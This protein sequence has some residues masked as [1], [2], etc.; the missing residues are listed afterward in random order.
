MIKFVAFDIDGTL[1]DGTI[2]YIG[3]GEWTQKF[4]IRDGFGIKLLIKEGIKVAFISAANITSAQY[5]AEMLGVEH[6]Y[7]GVK[8]KLEVLEKLAIGFGLSLNEVAYIGDELDDVPVIAAVGFGGTVIDG[9]LEAKKVS[10][11]VSTSKAGHGAVREFIEA[12]LINNK[13]KN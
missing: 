11:F 5:R 3:N 7:F 10:K 4:S 6:A 1:T 2:S 13:L 12:I 9:V 8:D